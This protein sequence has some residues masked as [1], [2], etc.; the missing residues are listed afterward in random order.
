MFN[1]ALATQ[2]STHTHAAA[3]LSNNGEPRFHN[4][5]MSRRVLCLRAPLLR[6]A[7]DGCSGWYG[8]ASMS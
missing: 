6:D 5:E 7:Q 8:G 3:H 4:V 1:S 2:C